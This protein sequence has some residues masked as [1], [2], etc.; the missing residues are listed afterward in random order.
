MKKYK[1]QYED[2]TGAN[3]SVEEF[4]SIEAAEAEIEKE[5]DEVKEYFKGRDYD[6]GD[7]VDHDGI[8]YKEIWDSDSGEFVRWYKYYEGEDNDWYE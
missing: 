8:P 3:T 6:Y 4:D 2:N 1:V 5:F 7:F